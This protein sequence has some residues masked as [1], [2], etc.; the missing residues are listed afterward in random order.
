MH[1]RYRRY[2]LVTAPQGFNMDD[3]ESEE[4]ICKVTP[5]SLSLPMTYSNHR[6]NFAPKLSNMCLH[7]RPTTLPLASL[8]SWTRQQLRWIRTRMRRIWCFVCPK[9]IIA[10]DD[11]HRVRAFRIVHPILHFLREIQPM[12]ISILRISRKTCQHEVPRIEGMI[13]FGIFEGC[14]VCESLPMVAR[15]ILLGVHIQ[16][17]LSQ[18]TFCTFSGN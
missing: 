12:K 5:L 11:R 16:R 18:E 1:P 8:R 10:S 7:I 15:S 17:S 6:V 3:D 14:I 2:Q 9:E 13:E 4:F